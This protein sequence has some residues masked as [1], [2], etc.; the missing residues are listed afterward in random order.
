MRMKFEGGVHR[1]QRVPRTE[2]SGR[3]HTSTVTVAI[4]SQP[5]EVCLSTVSVITGAI[6]NT[7]SARSLHPFKI[8]NSLRITLKKLSYRYEELTVL[9]KITQF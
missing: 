5:S 4:L 7:H 6:L 1:V 2:K 3:M 9:N 8:F